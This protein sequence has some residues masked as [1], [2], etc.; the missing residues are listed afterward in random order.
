MSEAAQIDALFIAR[1]LRDG[2]RAWDDADPYVKPPQLAKAFRDN[3]DRRI[4]AAKF[5]G[6]WSIAMA[7]KN[8]NHPASSDA[9]LVPREAWSKKTVTVEHAVPIKC[10]FEKFWDADTSD[11]MRQI[12]SAYEV[13][14]VT[15]EEDARLKAAGLNASMPEGWVLGRD[16][17]MARWQAVGIEVRAV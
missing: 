1:S 13:A 10:L 3:W 16:D 7:R 11:R 5:G 15:C 14:V 4:G 17:P 12:I 8:K 2:L 9:L 6:V